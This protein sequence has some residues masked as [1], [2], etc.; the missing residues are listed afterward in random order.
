MYK[1]VLAVRR[2]LL[3]IVL[4]A[5]FLSLSVAQTRI[6]VMQPSSF[7]KSFFDGSEV[8]MNIEV[9]YLGGTLFDVMA[10]GL[11]DGHVGIDF[12]TYAFFVF[13]G[14]GHLIRQYDCGD[15]GIYRYLLSPDASG[16]LYRGKDAGWVDIVDAVTGRV[17]GK[18]KL[19]DEV[20]A[21]V[22]R[23]AGCDGSY[24]ALMNNADAD[25]EADLLVFFDEKGNI[26]GRFKGKAGSVWNFGDKPNVERLFYV[27]GGSL[28][29][30]DPLDSGMVYRVDGGEVV[31][32]IEFVGVSDGMQVG[33]VCEHGDRVYF[34]I[35]GKWMCYDRDGQSMNTLSSPGLT[36]W[37][38]VSPEVLSLVMIGDNSY[39]L[40]SGRLK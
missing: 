12:L 18:I 31:P 32:H 34:S 35:G 22:V 16:L 9:P 37:S 30:H 40:Q 1:T 29:F 38:A 23:L 13:D 3:F 21:N 15:G 5:S 2:F 4:S 36:C 11:P 33:D 24:I 39:S 14:N 28:F 7:E 20:A 25:T 6:D 19:P 8:S 26:T 27:C 17:V 10:W